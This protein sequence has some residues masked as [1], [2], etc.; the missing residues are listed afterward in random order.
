MS[1]TDSKIISTVLIAAVSTLIPFLFLGN[2]SEKIKIGLALAAMGMIVSVI[3]I[4]SE[5]TEK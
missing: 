1:A 2:T 4:K 5:S 3:V